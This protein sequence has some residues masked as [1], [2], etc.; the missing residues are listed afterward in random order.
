ML[1]DLEQNLVTFDA[2]AGRVIDKLANE[3]VKRNIDK[4][5]TAD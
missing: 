1:G 5:A 2:L 4:R 3:I